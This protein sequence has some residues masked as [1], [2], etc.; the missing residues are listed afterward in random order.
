MNMSAHCLRCG[1]CQQGGEMVD[2]VIHVVEVVTAIK[3][4]RSV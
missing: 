3:G 2:G 4:D 1:G